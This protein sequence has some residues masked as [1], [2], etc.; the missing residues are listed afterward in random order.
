MVPAQDN[1]V[2]LTVA[3]RDY[4]LALSET[5]EVVG[6]CR[7]DHRPTGAGQ[8]ALKLD[9]PRA[10]EVIAFHREFSS[11]AMESLLDRVMKPPRAAP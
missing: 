5:G 10:R 11:P 6:V 8:R 2:R 1:S 7:L 9:G 4:R 3:G